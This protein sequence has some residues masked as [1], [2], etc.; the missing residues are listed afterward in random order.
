M[1]GGGGGGSHNSTGMC[2]H[3]SKYNNIPWRIS[4]MRRF[5]YQVTMS[6]QGSDYNHTGNNRDG[7][8]RNSQLHTQLRYFRSHTKTCSASLAAAAYIHSYTL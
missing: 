6:W 5:T 7:D 4:L 8:S 1:W 3:L 2:K